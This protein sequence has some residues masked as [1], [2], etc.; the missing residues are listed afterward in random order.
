MKEKSCVARRGKV[1]FWNETREIGFMTTGARYTIPPPFVQY[2]KSEPNPMQCYTVKE[3]SSLLH[4]TPHK[5]KSL[6]QRGELKF[7]YSGHGYAV[8]HAMLVEW[9]DK[10]IKSDPIEL[11]R[12]RLRSKS[13]PCT[14]PAWGPN[15]F[16]A[17]RAAPA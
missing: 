15:K 7:I 16:R 1:D 5:I 9:M 2:S 12:R 3:I 8:T 11:S 13:R 14:N 6:I 10:K 4:V 17:A